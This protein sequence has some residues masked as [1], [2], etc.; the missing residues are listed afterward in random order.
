MSSCATCL[1]AVLLAATTVAARVATAR[2]A[3]A[4]AAAAVACLAAAPAIARLVHSTSCWWGGLGLRT[5]WPHLASGSRV[6]ALLR[7]RPIYLVNSISCPQPWWLGRRP[8]LQLPMIGRL[9]HRQLRPRGLA[10]PVLLYLLAG[11]LRHLLV[12][13]LTAGLCRRR[14][15]FFMCLLTA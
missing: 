6:P 11:W 9:G 13:V 12:V 14:P 15:L 1:A 3:A 7:L 5:V 4:W 2:V 8:G 10:R